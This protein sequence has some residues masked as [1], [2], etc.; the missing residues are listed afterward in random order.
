[1]KISNIIFLSFL[2]FLFGGITLLFIGSK[3]YKGIDNKS[4]FVIQEKKTAAFSVVVAEQGAFLIL[5]NGS[6]FSVSQSYKK[7]AVPNFAPFEVRNDT[8]FMSAV[9]SKI[10]GKWFVV[11]EVYCKNVKS[12]IAKE[13][14]NVS[15]R[16]Y[17][18]DSLFVNLN[19]SDLS[20]DLNKTVFVSFISK[21][22]YVR[23]K[24]ENIQKLELQLDKTELNID[25]KKSIETVLGNLKNNSILNCS[26]D[27]KIS[28]E[29][30]KSSQMFF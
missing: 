5:K 15:L 27:G 21:N 7:D 12:I 29:V 30:D 11:P 3:Y 4:D 16:N 19:K 6:E 26:I 14:S 9:K 8:L 1:M 18:V 25:S 17:Q 13:K 24:G 20:G 10:D 2:I 28:L 22:S 23:F